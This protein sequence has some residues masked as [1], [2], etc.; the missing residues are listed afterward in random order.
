MAFSTT[1]SQLSTK[2]EYQ[3][4]LATMTADC[5][6]EFNR[7]SI[8]ACCLQ[9]YGWHS[10]RAHESNTCSQLSLAITVVTNPFQRPHSP[11]LEQEAAQG[12]CSPLVV[13]GAHQASL[14][15]L[16]SNAGHLGVLPL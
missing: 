2:E 15:L 13:V 9:F 4:F 12:S 8:E 6:Q 11:I 5:Q 3:E 7:Q 10:L 1:S 14:W 16:R